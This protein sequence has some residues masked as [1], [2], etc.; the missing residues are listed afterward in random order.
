MLVVLTTTPMMSTRGTA[1]R[2]RAPCCLVTFPF[3]IAA[4]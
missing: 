1:E 2:V 3:V 4:C